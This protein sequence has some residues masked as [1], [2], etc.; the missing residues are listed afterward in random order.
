M[1]VGRLGLN[2]GQNFD[3]VAVH[4]RPERFVEDGLENIIVAQ[5]QQ[6][7]KVLP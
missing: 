1:P 2:E 5:L 3:L 6:V 4:I 7:G